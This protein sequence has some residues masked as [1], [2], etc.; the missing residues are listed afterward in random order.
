MTNQQPKLLYV[1]VAIPAGAIIM[2]LY[3]EVSGNSSVGSQGR[4]ENSQ[5]KSIVD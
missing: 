5:V 3:D 4:D 2:F 1:T